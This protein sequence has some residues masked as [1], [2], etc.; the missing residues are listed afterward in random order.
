MF[1]LW[2]IPVINKSLLYDHFTLSKTNISELRLH[3]LLTYS[4]SHYNVM[5]ICKNN[6]ISSLVFNMVTL[7]FFGRT[8]EAH[9]GPK[10]LLYLYLLGALVGGIM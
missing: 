7:Y 2:H 6:N 4:I 8:I 3:T 1:A 9:F 5:H 10:R